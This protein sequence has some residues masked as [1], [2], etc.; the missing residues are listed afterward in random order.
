M[1]SEQ[2]AFREPTA[3]EHREILIKRARSDQISKLMAEYMLKGYRM[4]ATY[5][6]ECSNVLL[7]DK[8][9]K[10]YCVAC[11]EVDKNR[12]ET[13]GGKKSAATI[14]HVSSTNLGDGQNS[15]L[16]ENNKN[17]HDR[18]FGSMEEDR[19]NGDFRDRSMRKKDDHEKDFQRVPPDDKRRR[20]VSRASDV[21]S[22]TMENAT[23]KL[24]EKVE[25]KIVDQSCID[26]I[27]VIKSCAD[28]LRSLENV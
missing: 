11:Q 1:G 15:N 7:G 26:Y 3:E 8:S 22:A 18:F 16:N 14:F 25:R 9:G 12:G 13:V 4:L 23:N 27:N 19:L 2:M 28:A 21:V 10:D 20:I 5:C 17:D 6:P 24:A